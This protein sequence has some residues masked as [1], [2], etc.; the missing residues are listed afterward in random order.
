LAGRGG[1]HCHYINGS[2]D[3]ISVATKTPVIKKAYVVAI[4][5][6]IGENQ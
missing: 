4:L 5:E 3:V 1:S 6:R 2:G